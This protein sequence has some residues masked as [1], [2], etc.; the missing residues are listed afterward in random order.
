MSMLHVWKVMNVEETRKVFK[1]R[2]H[3]CYVVY[4]HPN[5][6]KS[7][8]IYVVFAIYESWYMYISLRDTNVSHWQTT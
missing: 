7:E 2:G 5:G 4:V 1:G 3:L 8:C 6:K